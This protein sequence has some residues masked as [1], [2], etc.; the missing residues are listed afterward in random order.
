MNCKVY[1]KETVDKTI[2]TLLNRAEFPHA[3]PRVK[4]QN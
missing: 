2:E 4:K 1:K 3:I